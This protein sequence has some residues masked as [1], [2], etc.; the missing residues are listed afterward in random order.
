MV[1]GADRGPRLSVVLVDDSQQLRA[2]VRHR[3]EQ[4]GLFDVVGEGGD[5]DEAISLVI[6][7]EPDLLLL[8]TSMP[9][10]DGLQ[11]LP[12][13]VAVCPD[14]TVVMFTGF[15]EAGLAERARELGAT[16]LV[17]KSLPL[18]ELPDRLMR[19][20]EGSPAPSDT[21][22]RLSLVGS[23]SGGTEVSEEQRVLDEHV[24][25]FQA[26]FDRAAIG[27]A[28]LTV[29][30][31]VVRA[32]NALAEL[33]SCEPYDLV[34]V[35]YGQLTRG[36]GDQLDRG[37]HAIT[38]RAKDLATVEHA[39]P[40]G[41]G[42]LP[43]RIVRLTLSPIRD[44]QQQVLY[45]FA[46][47]QD[48]TALRA[49]EGDLRLSEENFRLLIAAVSEYAIFMLDR[50][51]IV[52][53]WNAGAKRI[54]G[55]SPDEI[56]G[57]S[58]RVFYPPEDR[59]TGH[60]EQNLETARRNGEFAEEGW[61]V[62]KDGSRFWASVVIS[63][64]YDDAGRHIGFA[65]VTRDQS[66][67]RE[68][69]Q[70][71]KHLITEQTHLLAV[72]AHELRTP[73]AV[74]EGSVSALEASS[75]EGSEHDTLLANIVSSTHR[76]RRLA[77]DLSTASQLQR[78]TLQYRLDD[79]TLATILRGAAARREAAESGV[80]IDL[81]VADAVTVRADADRLGQ[82]IDNLLD[83]AVRHGHAPGHRRR[84]RGR[85]PRADQGHRRRPRRPRAARTSLV[86]AL[87]ER[88]LAGRHRPG[89]LPRA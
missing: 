33:M 83:N 62:R 57:R 21:R 8:D 78:G 72:T 79:V 88:R 1:T 9:T 87:R 20:L 86:R 35:D 63:A 61:R 89:P 68:H 3:L 84:G 15:E 71:R 11:A 80:H 45:V 27:M 48:I 74:I 43:P 6:R 40:D 38:V 85:R 64:V 69:E 75:E 41:A 81:E 23:A 7:H 31:T 22:V 32:N 14:T 77:A 36:A 13:I 4:S 18:E 34:G 44:A 42:G 19:A 26:L 2:L 16:D 50:D 58:F 54:K 56:V 59:A 37:L 24:A 29:T 82:A 46:Q 12:A 10:C 66:T 30:G 76:L 51:G 53:S 55:Y 52:V 73:T 70:E 39:L 17:E 67:Q 65:K 60:P 5:G 47:V 25:Q 49:V 28:T